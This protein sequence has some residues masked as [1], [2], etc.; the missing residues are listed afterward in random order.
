[1][2]VGDVLEL[3]IQGSGMDGEG[4]AR[5]DGKVVFVPFTLKGE[6][7]RAVVK[8]VKKCCAFATVIKVVIPSPHR[9]APRCPHYFKCGGC[10]MLHID[11]K[12]RRE[13]LLAEIENNFKK[14][15]GID[16]AVNTFMGCEAAV[17]N[18]YAMPFGYIGGKTVLGMYR[19]KTHAVEPVDCIMQSGRARF[20]AKLVCEF[21]NARRIGVYDGATGRGL[22]RHLVMRE[23]GERMSVTLTVNGDGLGEANEKA[24]YKALPDYVDLF[25]SPDK[26]RN[27]L[28]MGDT[29]RL[30]GGRAKLETEVLGVKAEL[31]PLSFFQVNDGVRDELYRAAI[32]NITAPVLVDLYSGIGITSN[33]AAKK[34]SRVI[35]VECVEAAVRDADRTAALNGN[36]DRIEN[37]CGNVEDVLPK[38]TN[39]IS[40]ADVLVDPPRKGCTAAVMNAVAAISP[41]RFVYIS[42]NH[43]TMCRDIRQFIDASGGNYDVTDVSAFDMFPGSHHV[44]VVAVMQRKKPDPA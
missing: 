35:A 14:I 10:D 36:A 34:C 19:R 39:E 38:M 25:V 32:G 2:N 43:A 30:I 9:V 40:G 26:S 41:S 8:T 44:E 13:I 27:N 15:A 4:V 29:V 31:S 1:M 33:L 7:V 20:V 16:I 28:V 11:E 23:A 12:H 22:L 21:M 5:V 42:C 6:R 18:K 17:R 24:L 3:D 37:I